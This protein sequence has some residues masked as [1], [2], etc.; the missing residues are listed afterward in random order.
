MSQTSE[1]IDLSSIFKSIKEI[2]IKSINF[3]IYVFKDSILN[4]KR[5]ISLIIFCLAIGVALYL[6]IKPAYKSQLII[7]HKRFSNDQC[8]ELI[9]ELNTLSIDKQ[10]NSL[11]EKLS[12]SKK[13]AQE[14]KSVH[15]LPLN[16]RLETLLE[17]SIKT[18]TP[19]KI[20]VKVYNNA[21]LPSIEKGI[22]NYLSTNEFV[23]LRE[24][25]DLEYIEQLDK[26]IS[27]QINSLDSLKSKIIKTLNPISQTGGVSINN[28]IDPVNIYL[29]ELDLY[30]TKFE[31]Q[32]NKQ[33]NAS[34]E[35]IQGFTENN[36][37][38][39]SDLKYTIII[40]LLVGY[41][42]SLLL[43]IYFQLIK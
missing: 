22:L 18:N 11:A 34:F 1:E 17:D 31:L 12:I 3:I 39:N 30:K 25:A 5:L 6:I 23:V 40:S 36:T 26:Q 24:K 4:V 37:P 8:A 28:P 9:N 14:I 7:D 42:V 19:F 13:E 29:R 10:T 21:T 27:V 2:I 15:F 41:L 16:E 38:Y 35:L 43:S 33:L 20:E 32:K